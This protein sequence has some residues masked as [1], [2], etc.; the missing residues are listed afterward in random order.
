MV[1]YKNNTK[2]WKKHVKKLNSKVK[3]IDI[4]KGII[5]KNALD[6][7]LEKSIQV[8]RLDVTPAYD[9]YL[10]NIYSTLKIND[11]K[12][13]KSRKLKNFK[14]VKRGILS[15]ENS[16]IVDDVNNPKIVYGISDGRGSFKKVSSKKISQIKKN[17]RK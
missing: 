16:I 12:L 7:L 4:G 6:L 5:D 17:L 3:I 10:E 15:K 9:G 11:T 14:L 2:Q 8:Y 13:K 1:S